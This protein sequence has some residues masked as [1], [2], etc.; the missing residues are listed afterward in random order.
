MIDTF[1]PDANYN[2]QHPLEPSVVIQRVQKVES[3]SQ[4]FMED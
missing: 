2:D 4:V 3:S 1:R